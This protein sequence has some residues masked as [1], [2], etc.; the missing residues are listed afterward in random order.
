MATKPAPEQNSAQRRWPRYRFQVPVR[1]TL[2]GCTEPIR[3]VGTELNEG[4]IAVY[5]G[6]ELEIGDQLNLE[7]ESHEWEHPVTVRGVVCNRPGDG[8]YYGVSFLTTRPTERGAL[9]LLRQMLRSAVGHL[10]S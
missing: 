3:A 4:G 7:F 9:V 2:D 6:V 1:I 8:Y 10:D 5:A